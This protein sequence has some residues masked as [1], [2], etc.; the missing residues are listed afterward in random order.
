MSNLRSY[1]EWK[2]ADEPVDIVYIPI[3]ASQV[4][5]F[6]PSTVSFGSPK[7]GENNEHFE[8]HSSSPPVYQ[9]EICIEKYDFF[10]KEGGLFWR[11]TQH[12]PNHLGYVLP[13]ELIMAACGFTE[14]IFETSGANQSDHRAD[15]ECAIFL[16]TLAIHCIYIYATRIPEYDLTILPS[17]GYM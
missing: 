7:N 11:C 12:L 6:L 5:G 17:Y 1:C 10:V 13:P 14:P 3:F 9:Q 15:S 8:S 16:Y 2:K 4:A